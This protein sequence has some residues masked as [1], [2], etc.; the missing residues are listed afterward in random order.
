MKETTKA[1]AGIF[2]LTLISMSALGI[3]PSLSAI[4]EA[5]PEGG[6]TAAQMLTAIPSLIGIAAAIVVGKIA[7]HT[8]KKA[9]GLF[10][11]LCIAVGGLLPY[12]YNANLTFLLV[13]SGILGFGVGTITNVTQLLFTEFLPPEERQSAMALNTAFVSVGAMFMTT[14]GGILAAGGWRNNYLVY[15]LAVVVLIAS[16]ILIPNDRDKVEEIKE[17]RAEAPK[18]HLKASSIVVGLLGVAFLALYNA[19]MNNMAMHAIS[20]GIASP[21]TV[22][23]IAGMAGTIA[24]LAG[25]LCGLVLGKLLPHF[26]K[27]SFFVA[28]GLLGIGLIIVGLS[29]NVVLYYAG[30]FLVGAM[31]SI[32]MSQAPFVLSVSNPPYLMAASMAIYSAGTSIGGFVSPIVL[33]ALSGAFAGGSPSGTLVIAGIIGLAIAVALGV[34]G[35][36]RK[37]LDK[38]FSHN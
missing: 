11:A 28:F 18:A 37:V 35:F 5:F 30:A 34:T 23:T 33:N 12:L 14:V 3:T 1:K 36:Q 31:L 26:Q 10:G 19:L 38:A 24:N 9:I 22:S 25:L 7:N 8:S 21:E 32:F 17:E 4:A 2:S 6:A 27:Q 16:A 29:T 13:C 15:L 20:S